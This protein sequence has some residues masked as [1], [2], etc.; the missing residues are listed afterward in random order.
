MAINFLKVHCISLYF[1]EIHCILRFKT[2]SENAPAIPQST[3]SFEVLERRP[4][5]NKGFGRGRFSNFEG[6]RFCDDQK[7]KSFDVL[8]SKPLQNLSF[9]RVCVSKHRTKTLLRPPQKRFRSKFSNANPSKT[10][11][12]EGSA[13]QNIEPNCV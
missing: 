6:N 10:C 8:K 9:G 2:S 7:K 12:L 3:T 4:L 11:V 13:F 1:I 5:Q